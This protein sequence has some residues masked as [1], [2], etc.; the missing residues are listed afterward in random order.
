LSKNEKGQGKVKGDQ[1]PIR[2]TKESSPQI[3]TEADKTGIPEKVKEKMEITSGKKSTKEPKV[4]NKPREKR[5]KKR[6]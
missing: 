5:L 4:K 2:K 1:T 3:L 6:K